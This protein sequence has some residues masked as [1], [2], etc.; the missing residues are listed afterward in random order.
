MFRVSLFRF[1][2]ITRFEPELYLSCA[3]K[4]GA[5]LLRDGSSQVVNT[6]FGVAPGSCGHEG[7]CTTRLYKL[8]AVKSCWISYLLILQ[9]NLLGWRRVQSSRTGLG[10]HFPYR[11]DVCRVFF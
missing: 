7:H 8:R 4:K 5:E 10:R 6:T 3:A 2:R 11:R 9:A 1:A